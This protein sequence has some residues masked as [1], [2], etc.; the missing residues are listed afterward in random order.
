MLPTQSINQQNDPASTVVDLPAL[1]ANF[2]QAPTPELA[3]DNVVNSLRSLLNDNVYAAAVEGP[4]G[5][6]KTTVLAQFVRRHPNA[7]VSAFVSAANKLSFDADL[8]RMD[9]ATQIYFAVTGDILQREKYEPALLKSNYSDL[10]RVAKRKKSIVYF[11]VDGLEE[12]DANIREHL[13]QQLTDILPIGVPQFRFLFSGDGA[14][15]A[16]LFGPKLPVKPFPLT[17]ISLE[18]TKLLF[19][20]HDLTS[21]DLRELYGL[22][23]GIPGRLSSILRAAQAGLSIPAFLQDPPRH[24]PEF[25]QIE[26]SQVPE[27]DAVLRR[28]LALLAHD[29]KPHTVADVAETLGIASEVVKGKIAAVT[30][31]VIDPMNAHIHLANAALRKFI[32]ERLADRKPGI[33]KL[34]I[35]RL[36]RNPDSDDAV[37]HLPEYLEDAAQFQDLLTLLTPDHILQ[38]LERSQTLSRVEDAVHRGFRSAER[39]G[40]DPDLLRFGIQQSVIAELAASN[41]WESE[42]GALSSLGRDSEALAL[43]NDAVLKE[44]RLQLLAASAHGTWLRGLAVTPELLDQIG[45]LIDNLDARALGR[46]AQ[47]IASQLTCVSPD[48]A[49]LLLR[50]TKLDSA[51]DNE[52]DRAFAHL[53][54]HALNDLKDERRRAEAL[55]TMTISRQDPRARSLLQGVRVLSGRLTAAEVCARVDDIENPDAKIQVLRHW[56][57]LNGDRL[58]A[59][60][61]AHHGLTTALRTTSATLD[62][63][64]LADLST[65]LSGSGDSD[66]KKSLIAAL[67]GVRGTA[68]RLGP[69]VDYVRLQLSLAGA[70]Y[71]FD[72]GGAEGRLMELIDYVARISDVSS[73]GEAYAHLL[74]HLNLLDARTSFASGDSLETQCGNE[75]ETVVLQ[76]ALST[77]DHY[78]ALNGIITALAKGYLDKALEYIRIV[79]TELRRDAILGEV[80]ETLLRRPV[81]DISPVGLLRVLDEIRRSVDRDR[82]TQVIMERFADEADVPASVIDGLL[83][84]ISSLPKM[85]DSGRACRSMVCA[86]NLLRLH[87]T[88]ARDSLRENIREEIHKRWAQID[89]GWSRIDTGFAIAKD[90]ALTSPDDAG[91]MLLETE[92]LKNEWRIAAHRPAAAYVACIGLVIRALCGLLPKKLETDT[93]LKALSALIDILPAYGER[94]VLWA[95]LCMRC[96]LVGRVDLTERLVKEF[97][98]PALNNVPVGDRA[99]RA[100]VLVRVAPA[101]F[102]VLPTTCLE[103]LNS[104]EV[105][106]RD[107]A[108]R[109]IARFMLYSRAPSDPVEATTTRCRGKFF[110]RLLS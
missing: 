39:L 17:E 24:N 51:D 84:L 13:L 93:D 78:L 94:A 63:S 9:I 72:R 107:S 92:K 19:S 47:R 108:L 8:I 35:K 7:A 32:A 11:V 89:M 98:Q 49:T 10:Q 41:V 77:A 91:R 12:L 46:R 62:A 100:R 43:A 71:T 87:P 90:L 68:E 44:D 97:V 29:A 64:L 54:I 22:C 109:G 56:C 96:S 21:E 73:R 16:P 83:P 48:L 74:A 69:S 28:I 3:R 14:L 38:V 85:S 88:K 102:R 26:W 82:A 79:N 99:Y 65:A 2:P 81:T 36:L 60:L 20:A 95:D 6:G 52:L 75:L 105:D 4:E 110:A 15:Y 101:L 27:N 30:F 55:D 70:E 76:L 58:D 45:L 42:V 37:L 5:A 18:E 25:F 80:I 40:K 104:L 1:S 53:T 61:V 106:D 33:Q 67:D 57:V 66:R 86:V 103:M 50:K 31:V 23:G 34:L 59:D